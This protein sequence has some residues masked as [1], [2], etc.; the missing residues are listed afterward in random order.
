MANDMGLPAIWAYNLD[1]GGRNVGLILGWGN[2]VGNLGAAVSALLLG[3]V[4]KRYVDFD[5]APT[6][7]Q[8]KAGY[9]AVFLTCAAVFVLIG[10]VSLF[11]DATKKIGVKEPTQ[12]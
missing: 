4:L 6:I 12:G 11:V 3:F 9:G 7:A 8:M 5:A 10:I 1:V 2:M